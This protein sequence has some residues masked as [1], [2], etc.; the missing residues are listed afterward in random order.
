[1]RPSMSCLVK[2]NFAHMSIRAGRVTRL[3]VALFCSTMDAIRSMQPG[4]R[5]HAQIETSCMRIPHG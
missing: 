1:M 4:I 5:S 3:R 2:N